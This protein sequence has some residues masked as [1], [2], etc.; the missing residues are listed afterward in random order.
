MTLVVHTLQPYASI[1]LTLLEYGLIFYHFEKSSDV[2]NPDF[3][4]QT[5]FEPNFF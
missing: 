3:W 2:I 5:E 4:G 1:S